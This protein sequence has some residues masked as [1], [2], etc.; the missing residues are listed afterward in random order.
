MELGGCDV[1]S[2]TVVGHGVENDVLD[3]NADRSEYKGGEEV[4]VDVITGAVQPSFC[5]RV[6]KRT[7]RGMSGCDN[8][9][10]HILLHC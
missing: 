5:A 8:N 6:R 4:N 2:V 3:K 1:C 7:R 9:N 10:L